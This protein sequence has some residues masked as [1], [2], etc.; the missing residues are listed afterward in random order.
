MAKD[1][2]DFEAEIETSCKEQ[3]IFYH[4]IKDVF[5]PPDQRTRIRVPKNKYDSMI[6][7]KNTLFPIEFKSIKA[8][9]I[10]IKDPK[11]VKPHQIEGLLEAN[12]YDGTIPGFIINFRECDNQTFFIHIS[13]FVEYRNCLLEGICNRKYLNKVNKSSLSLDIAKEIGVPISN[14]KKKT[15][16]RYYINKLLDELIEKYR[17]V[18]KQ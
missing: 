12:T 3:H 1:G 4:R 2:R 13:D 11:I 17:N 8:K 6:F 15:N 14:I 18:D 5:I 9:S 16:Y 7:Y 10:N